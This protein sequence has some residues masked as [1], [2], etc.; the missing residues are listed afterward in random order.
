MGVVR[1]YKKFEKVT[2]M[3]VVEKLGSSTKFSQSELFYYKVFGKTGIHM[4]VIGKELYLNLK[5]KFKVIPNIL[6]DIELL[7]ILVIIEYL[8]VIS[9]K[10]MKLTHVSSPE[11]INAIY[12]ILLQVGILGLSISAWK[13]L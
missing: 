8:L 13:W 11:Q 4:K 2:K 9:Y 12:Y 3:K 6:N 5:E 1:E 10:F 7:L